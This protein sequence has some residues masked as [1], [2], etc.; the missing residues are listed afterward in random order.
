M[1]ILDGLDIILPDNFTMTKYISIAKPCFDLIIDLKKQ[2]HYLKQSR[3]ILLPRLMNG[4][5]TVT[6]ES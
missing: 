3:D 5:I 6:P 1:K 2:N 4:S